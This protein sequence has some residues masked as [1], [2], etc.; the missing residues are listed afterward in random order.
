M[1]TIPYHAGRSRLLANA[2]SLDALSKFAEAFFD[3]TGRILDAI[4]A[5]VCAR[6]LVD[7]LARASSSC[8]NDATSSVCDAADC[9][10]ELIALGQSRSRFEY[11]QDKSNDLVR[12]S[13]PVYDLASLQM[14]L[15]LRICH[16][17]A[18]TMDWLRHEEAMTRRFRWAM[19]HS[20]EHTNNVCQ[21]L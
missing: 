2:A 21:G 5:F 9:V 15:L 11:G 7:G 3:T 18:M 6:S 10:A 8:A 12:E 14:E 17:S 13:V 19:V 16:S 1:L 20:A 4:T